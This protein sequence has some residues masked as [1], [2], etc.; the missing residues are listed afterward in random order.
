MWRWL[1]VLALLTLWPGPAAAFDDGIGRRLIEDYGIPAT[2][3]F[4][5]E[6]SDLAGAART[7]CAEPSGAALV[8]VRGEFRRAAVSY[9]GVAF[10][11][12]GPLVEENRG[13]RVFFFPDVRGIGLRQIQALIADPGVAMLLPA[14]MPAKSAALQGLPALE[15]VLFGTD[16]DTLATPG[17]ALRCTIASAIAG[18]LAT[19]GGEI[20]AI[21]T[22]GIAFA[23]DFGAP[24]PGNALYRSS[25]EVAREALKAIAAG[26]AF[27]HDAGLAAA[28]GEDAAGARPRLAPLWRSGVTFAFLANELDGIA[29]FYAASGLGDGLAPESVWLDTAFRFEL[30]QAADALRRVTVLPEAAFADPEARGIISYAAIATD[31]LRQTAGNIAAALGLGTGFIAEEGGD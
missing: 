28:L 5:A 15:F 12:F 25:E 21:W 23:D 17:G 9:G 24:A 2:S 26:L 30:R 11:R 18:N 27:V 8:T 3:G 14:A 31:S 19:L 6:T 29:A 7:L 10:L 1:P 13:D 4:S 20:A 22:P 16:S